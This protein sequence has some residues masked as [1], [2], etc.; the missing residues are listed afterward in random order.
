MILIPLEFTHRHV[1][2][3][4]GNYLSFRFWFVAT[5]NITLTHHER[6][7]GVSNHQQFDCLSNSSFGIKPKETSKRCINIPLWEEPP[8]TGWFPSQR[9]NNVENVFMAWRHHGCFQCGPIIH[10]R[11]ISKCMHSVRDFMCF[12]TVQG[13]FI[14]ILLGIISLA[15]G[16]SWDCRNAREKTLQNVEFANL[17]I[18]AIKAHQNRVHIVWD[19]LYCW[20]MA[21]LF[22]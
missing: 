9:A 11:Y 5:L 2:P 15:L 17:L 21:K 12:V 1:Y 20:H 16:K 14:H 10:V 19:E 18:R 6:R 8:M 13:G 7:H 22:R 3:I 4:K